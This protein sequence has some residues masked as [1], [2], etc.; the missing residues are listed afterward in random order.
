MRH[1]NISKK[2]LE[3]NPQSWLAQSGIATI[4]RAQAGIENEKA[5]KDKRTQLSGVYVDLAECFQELAASIDHLDGQNLPK[6]DLVNF[7]KIKPNISQYYLEAFASTSANGDQECD[8]DYIAN[9]VRELH[10]LAN[11]GVHVADADGLGAEQQSNDR[12][13][14]FGLRPPLAYMQTTMN[15]LVEAAKVPVDNGHT[16][17]ISCLTVFDTP[18]EDFFKCIAE[19]S[20]AADRMNWL[21]G[22]YREAIV[23]AT[24][25]R[26]HVAAAGLHLCLAELY[27]SFSNEPDKAICI[28][29]L[30]GTEGLDSI[31]LETMIV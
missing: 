25:G 8:C 12:E 26:E 29:E 30:S 6:A 28:W 4:Y 10:F 3:I 11:F 16:V 14:R 2:A 17:L 13:T 22:V 23:A 7:V 27:V 5:G 31:K 18:D 20:K 19:A 24:R 1:L 9:S 15:I 21:E